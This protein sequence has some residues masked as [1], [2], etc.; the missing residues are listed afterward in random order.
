MVPLSSSPGCPSV[1]VLQTFRE[2]NNYAHRRDWYFGTWNVRSLVDNEGSVETARISSKV[3]E[4]ED[5]RIDLVL[6]ELDRYDIKIAALQETKWF[7]RN[8]Y[9]VDKS[10][11][12]SAGGRQ[13]EA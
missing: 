12:L 1:E 7:G 2:V 13:K 10:V 9:G 6:R 3:A 4:L 11:V 5:R 8:I